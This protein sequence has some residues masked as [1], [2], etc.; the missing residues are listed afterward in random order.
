VTSQWG[1]HGCLRSLAEPGCSHFTVTSHGSSPFL[2]LWRPES[3]PRGSGL[4]GVHLPPT[5]GR[6]G[7]CWEGCFVPSPL[8]S[9]WPPAG[10]QLTRGQ[11]DLT[12]TVSMVTPEHCA[13]SWAWLTLHSPSSPTAQARCPL[14]PYPLGHPTPAPSSPRT[15]EP[16]WL[17]FPPLC[18]PQVSVPQTCYSPAPKPDRGPRSLRRLC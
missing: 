6:C 18:P 4:F 9:L 15:Y 1:W 17:P 11:C 13:A 7:E 8:S 14:P 16:P 3:G 5:P 10:Q 2:G 12:S